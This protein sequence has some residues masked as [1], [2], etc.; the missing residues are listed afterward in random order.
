MKRSVSLY[1]VI[2]VAFFLLYMLLP[3]L[4]TY[5]FSVATRWDR[6]VL[7]EGYTLSGTLLPSRTLILVAP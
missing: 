4:A 5:V 3:I 2:L 1:Q 7:P 6:T